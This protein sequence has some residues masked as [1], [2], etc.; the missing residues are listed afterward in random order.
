MFLITL[1]VPVLTR[2]LIDESAISLQ[3]EDVSNEYE[4]KS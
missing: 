1:V 2:D 4:P 3:T